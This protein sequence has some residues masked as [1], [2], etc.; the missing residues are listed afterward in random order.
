MIMLNIVARRLNAHV[1]LGYFSRDGTTSVVSGCM[2]THTFAVTLLPPP[3][4]RSGSD[5]VSICLERRRGFVTGGAFALSSHSC[6]SRT[7]GTFTE[8][9]VDSIFGDFL[10]RGWV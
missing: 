1:K 3:R 4:Q 9:M 5:H 8:V 2:G 10:F 6:N 7:L